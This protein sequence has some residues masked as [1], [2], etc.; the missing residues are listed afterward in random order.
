MV[1]QINSLAI[2][3]HLLISVAELS[4]KGE[5]SNTSG[6]LGLLLLTIL[7]ALKSILIYLIKK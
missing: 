4:G 5:S 2:F 7:V 6:S 1:L 3:P